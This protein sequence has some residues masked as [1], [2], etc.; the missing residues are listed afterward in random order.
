MAEESKSQHALK[1]K[2]LLRGKY[3]ESNLAVAI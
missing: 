1:Y 3:S 2:G